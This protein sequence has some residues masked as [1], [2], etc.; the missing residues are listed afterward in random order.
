MK[1]CNKQARHE[2]QKEPGKVAIRTQSEDEE[3]GGKWK[4][5]NSSTA[6]KT[7]RKQT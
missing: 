5:F 4:V 2:D 3:Q 7:A 6:G 1:D